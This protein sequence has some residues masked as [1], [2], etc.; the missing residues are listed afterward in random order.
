MPEVEPRNHP[1]EASPYLYRVKTKTALMVAN[2]DRLKK[3]NDRDIP[4]WLARYQE[5]I[6]SSQGKRAVE[7]TDE[8]DNSQPKPARRGSP[9]KLSKTP[10]EHHRG[11]GRPTTGPVQ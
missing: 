2:H 10:E 1:Q 8:N 6:A 4:L 9:R 11:G 3:C 5:K 7:S